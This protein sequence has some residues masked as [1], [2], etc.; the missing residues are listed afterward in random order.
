MTQAAGEGRIERLG[1]NNIAPVRHIPIHADQSWMSLH[2]F[3]YPRDDPAL[4]DVY[5]YTDAISYEP[6]ETVRFHTSSTAGTWTLEIE[7][8]GARPRSVHRAENL[9]GAHHPTPTDA[10]SKGCGWP[11]A[12]S[13]TIPDDARSGFYKVISSCRRP[14]G[15]PFVQHHFF[16]V[17]PTAATQGGKLLMILPTGTWTS[18]NDWGGANHYHGVDGVERNQYSP[19]L[20]LERPWTRG[21][22]WL[23][24]GAPR[25][26]NEPAAPLAEP[27]YPMKEWAYANGFGYYYAAAGWAQ[28]DRH[29]AVWAER[30]GYAFDM[31]AQTDLHYR[32]EILDRYLAI[33]IVGHDEYWSHAMRST[34][35]AYVEKG[36]RLARFGANFTWQIRLEDEGRRQVCYK[37]RAPEEDPVS[38]T[39]DARFLSTAWEDRRVGWPGASTVGV[40]GLGGVYAGWGAFVPRSQ[41]GFTTYRPEHWIFE[42]THLSYGDVFGAEARI[43]SYEV[44]GLDYTFRHG[45]PYPTGEDGASTD[46]EIL[47]M[48]PATLT[49][50]QFEGE[51]FRYYIGD[52]D[53]LGKADMV[54]GDDSPETLAKCRYGSGMVVHMKRGRGEVLT[55]ATCE[56]VMGLKRNDFFTQQITRNVL[57][58]FLRD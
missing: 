54:Y 11:V 47:A 55:A 10:Y 33:V 5:T 20:S 39:A 56:W 18:Y 48:A 37:T 19:V 50:G 13:W 14:D 4:P 16:V 22:V 6:G 26:C 2:W 35:E 44:D 25:L 3:E 43:F 31:I 7:L 57:D 30:E 38:G 49:E 36:G 28:F 58:R 17:R 8:D 1:P 53:Q 32:P 27:R 46:I 23:P 45:L 24:D 42:G 52:H 29:F 21:M 51:G 41:H 12:H 15:T 40:N 34:I 9:A